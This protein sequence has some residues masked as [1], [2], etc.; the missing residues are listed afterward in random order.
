MKTTVF[1]LLLLLSFS[2]GYGQ[3]IVGDWNGVLKV[4]EVKLRLVLHVVKTETGFKSTLDSPD[5]GASGIPATKTTFENAELH[6]AVASLNLEYDGTMRGDSIKGRFKQGGQDLPLD[7]VRVVKKVLKRPQEPA[8]PYSY[9]AED[10]LFKNPQANISLAGTLSLPKAS[11]KYP[12]VILISGSGPQN[13]DEELLGHKP[14]LVI[15]D[16]L[17]KNGIAVLRFDDRGVAKSQGDFKKATIEDFSSDV[18]SAI[19]YLR[20]RKE[21]DSKRIG[22]IGHSEGGIIAPLIAAKRSDVNFIVMLAGP[23]IPGYELLLLQKAK[24]ESHMGLPAAAAEESLN[25]IKGAYEIV[26]AS[27][28]QETELRKEVSSYFKSKV[29][30]QMPESQLNTIV[31]QLTSPWFIGLLKYDPSPVLSKV[32][33]PVLALNGGKDL[34]V[35]AL[36]N[37]AGIR[38]ALTKGG[39]S[40][41]TVKEFPALNHLFQECKTCSVSEYADLEESFSPMVLDEMTKWLSNITGLKK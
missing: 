25:L 22:L 26:L 18:E 30:D 9:H 32:K 20:T 27:D 10:V 1:L 21:I 36:E 40:N 39:N 12:A 14:F 41:V 35:P 34:Q 5:Q 38:T 33:C 4:G 17:T 7:L 19:A 13:R 23:G 15:A 29:G 8:K 3:E 16:H 28:A 24:I 37:L 6:V 11:G 2:S 31:S